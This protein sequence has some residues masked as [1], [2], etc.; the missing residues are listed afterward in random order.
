MATQTEIDIFLKA[1]Y[2]SWDRSLKDRRAYNFAITVAQAQ[3]G[4]LIGRALDANGQIVFDRA[5][6]IDP[7]LVPTFA[8]LTD[9][10]ARVSSGAVV[11]NAN[12]ARDEN[13]SA[14]RPSESA[15]VL[16]PDGRIEPAGNPPGTNAEP[17]PTT[18]NNPT[19]GTNA[20]VKTTA[21]TQAIN[22]QSNRAT[23]T[24]G[25][26]GGVGGGASAAV[27]DVG[28]I[29][30]T[31]SRDDNTQPR[32][33]V[34]TNRLD[35]LFAGKIISPGSNV[36]D[37]Y[38]S[39]T[40]ALSWYL[41]DPVSFGRTIGN[42]QKGLN[43]YYLLAQSG[44]AGTQAGTGEPTL[45][46]GT[47]FDPEP[48]SLT[49][50][51]QRSPYFSLDYYLDNLSINTA[52]GSTGVSGGPM[53]FLTLGFTVSE[54]NGLTL[55]KNLYQAVND[56]YSRAAGARNLRVNY[57]T[58]LYCMVIRFYGYDEAGQ[59]A[60]PINNSADST[61]AKAAVEKFIFFTLTKFDYSLGSKLVEYKIEGASLETA[62]GFSSDRGS[63]PFAQQFTGATVK[64]ILVGQ[65]QQQTAAQSAG[66][67]T[68][69]EKP[70]TSSPNGGGGTGINS[71]V[72]QAERDRFANMAGESSFL[73][74]IRDR[75]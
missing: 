46:I 55:P 45:G 13:A 70:V 49:Q 1:F 22:N 20:P 41:V 42:I 63:I 7:S 17:T 11:A 68:R 27:T 64:D 26:S 25:S 69:N 65:I 10:L 59:L 34:V 28:T 43:G 5:G 6:L 51:A 66:D 57:A 53:K 23:A 33:S 24:G 67:A 73:N 12:L 16:N 8:S 58:G 36:L 44:G 50:G 48:E 31:A 56:V 60:M 75:L 74:R 19:T 61:D 54:P 18:Q 37:N 15:Q 2:D 40:Y 14:Q 62:V 9:G 72:T 32:P 21:Q 38:A 35:N 30:I 71:N 4:L 3:S 39:Y 29:T 52:Y 47:G